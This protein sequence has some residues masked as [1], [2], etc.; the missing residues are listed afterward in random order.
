M[1]PAGFRF[2]G[3]PRPVTA[4]LRMGIGGPLPFRMIRRVGEIVL[5][6]DAIVNELYIF[7]G[8]WRLS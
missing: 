6:K 4:M 7:G 3:T 1:T 5:A 2:A 8:L